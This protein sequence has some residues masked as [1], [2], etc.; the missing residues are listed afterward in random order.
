MAKLLEYSA[1]KE[2][3]SVVFILWGMYLL[4]LMP[5]P[6]VRIVSESHMLETDGSHGHTYYLI[7]LTRQAEIHFV[8]RVKV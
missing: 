3:L 1:W 4:S 7:T 6:T 5:A 8:V 2:S